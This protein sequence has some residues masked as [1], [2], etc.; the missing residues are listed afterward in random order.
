MRSPIVLSLFALSGC[1]NVPVVQQAAHEKP[2]QGSTMSCSEPYAF[3]QDCDK[4]SGG[5]R[6]LTIEG[7]DV[8]VAA[9][10]DGATIVIFDAHPA[11][12]ILL[13]NPLI[14]N[15]PRH[16]KVANAAYEV[17]RDALDKSGFKI[18]RA[19]PVK[20]FADTSGYILHLDGNGYESLKAYTTRLRT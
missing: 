9:T 3:T 19:I 11:K 4:W 1:V 7:V 20:T 15:S 2:I 13:N 18:V 17:V 5:A 6:I 10:Q 8:A 16:S 14:L 12:N